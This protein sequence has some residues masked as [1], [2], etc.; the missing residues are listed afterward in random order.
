MEEYYRM[1]TSTEVVG[2]LNNKKMIHI[3]DKEISIIEKAGYGLKKDTYTWDGNKT[4]ITARLIKSGRQIW[5]FEDEWY[6]YIKF[7]KI[8]YLCDQMDG[9]IKCIEDRHGK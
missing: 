9:L 1:I 8:Y 5:A 4:F 3:T 7:G 2:M 6:I